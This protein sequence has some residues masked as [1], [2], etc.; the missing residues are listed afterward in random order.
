M[1]SP[2][3]HFIAAIVL[4]IAA[5]T[6][7]SIW[8]S[9]VSH[10]SQRVAE[11]QTRIDDANKNV[12]RIAS[13]RAALAEIAD[14]EEK[15]RSYFVAES[16]VVAF[17][18]TLEQLGPKENSVVKV[19]SVSTS[20]LPAQPLLLLTLS[21]TGTFDAVMRT[22]GAVE[23]APFDLLI[24]KLSVTQNEKSIWQANLTLTVGSAPAPMTATTTKRTR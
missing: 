11:L 7:Y 8:Y 18:T 5:V 1:R 22:V 15:V 13:A 23:Y 24:T 4:G 3:T 16:G 6:A 9:V 2:L 21:I 17:I 20:G 19:L 10:E 12:S 14:D